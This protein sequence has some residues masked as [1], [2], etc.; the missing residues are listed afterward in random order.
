MRFAVVLLLTAG[1]LAAGCTPAPAE[2]SIKEK[3]AAR[4]AEVARLKGWDKLFAAPDATIGA[5]NQ[6]GFRA[7]PYAA[8]GHVWRSTGGPVMIAGS[9]AKQP[10]RVTFAAEGPSATQ[11]DTI[12]F[13]LGVSDPKT[14]KDAGKRFAQIVRDFLFQAGIEGDALLPALEQG[15]PAR[16]T[17]AGTPYTIELPPTVEGGEGHQIVT[18]TRTGATAPANSKPQGN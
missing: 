3:E 9:F 7:T 8:S 17:L 10:N 1:L 12:R 2:K 5:A 14:A 13:D 6:F 15:V 4:A 18:F 11:V 16:G